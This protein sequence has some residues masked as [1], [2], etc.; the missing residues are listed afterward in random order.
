MALAVL[1]EKKGGA[2]RERRRGGREKTLG[3][4]EKALTRYV[5][6]FD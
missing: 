6:L 3:E 1:G 2:R 5:L 4:G